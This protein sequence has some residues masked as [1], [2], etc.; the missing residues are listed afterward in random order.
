MKTLYTQL[1]AF[2]VEILLSLPVCAETWS[3]SAATAIPEG[4]RTSTTKTMTFF[5]PLRGAG[6]R[7]VPGVTGQ[8]IL[9]LPVVLPHHTM[10]RSMNFKVDGVAS[11]KVTAN[12][13]KQPTGSGRPLLIGTLSIANQTCQVPLIAST[14]IPA[15]MVDNLENT[16]FVRI[17]LSKNSSVAAGS[18]PALYHIGVSDSLGVLAL[19]ARSLCPPDPSPRP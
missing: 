13:Y 11:A 12:L 9:Y 5:D 17:E 6:V 19:A 2:T 1:A 18:N 14:D 16:Y 4:A 7:F 8:A 10:L 15:H 3:I